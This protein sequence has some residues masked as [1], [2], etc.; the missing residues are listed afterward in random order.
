M[1]SCHSARG[2]SL[3]QAPHCPAPLRWSR[4]VSGFGLK[5]WKLRLSRWLGIRADTL[6]LGI[7]ANGRSCF[8]VSPWRVGVNSVSPESEQRKMLSPHSSSERIS[9]A[10]RAP[11]ATKNGPTRDPEHEKAAEGLSI[12]KHLRPP[13]AWE[14]VGRGG[15]GQQGPQPSTAPSPTAS[16]HV[17]PGVTGPSPWSVCAAEAWDQAVHMLRAA[18]LHTFPRRLERP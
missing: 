4:P 1:L 15:N 16:P 17:S 11:P 10:V 2:L 8:C 7:A 9:E 14:R 13:W 5:P 6:A 3:I 12:R 18:C